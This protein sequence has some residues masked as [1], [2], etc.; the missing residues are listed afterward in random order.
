MLTDD[1]TLLVVVSAA[2]IEVFTVVTVLVALAV[3]TTTFVI[4][5]KHSVKIS[6]HIYNLCTLFTLQNMLANTTYVGSNVRS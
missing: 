2:V 6:I 1:V 3:V 5:F 4:N